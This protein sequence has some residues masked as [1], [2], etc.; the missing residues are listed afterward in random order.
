MVPA[1]VWDVSTSTTAE[2]MRAASGSRSHDR[3]SYG[4]VLCTCVVQ[5]PPKSC[6]PST[7]LTSVDRMPRKY[8]ARPP[9]T[10]P[11]CTNAQ[12]S[13]LDGRPSLMGAPTMCL[14]CGFWSKSDRRSLWCVW[15]WPSCR[16]QQNSAIWWL[17][18]LPFYP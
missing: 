5:R 7:F 2:F 16:I 6:L 18:Y 9:P 1:R 3:L 15:S 12:A 14:T 17:S 10:Q 8:E 4:I 13:R 11:L